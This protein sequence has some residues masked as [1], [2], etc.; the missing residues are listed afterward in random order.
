VKRI[1]VARFRCVICVCASRRQ[2][3]DGGSARRVTPTTRATIVRA[4]FSARL[5]LA[6]AAH[7]HAFH[8]RHRHRHPHARAVRE[9]RRVDP[10]LRSD[11]TAMQLD[12]ILGLV[13]SIG[14]AAY[15]FFVLARPEKF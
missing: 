14:L 1:G 10:R 11:V 4:A 3:A 2:R 5:M 15:L 6:P 13:T 8:D 9:L 12:V 7:Q